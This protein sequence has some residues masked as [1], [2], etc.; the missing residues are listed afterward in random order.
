MSA[1]MEGISCAVIDVLNPFILNAFNFKL[2]LR[3]CGFA[4]TAS[5]YSNLINNT[6]PIL[7]K[8]GC[9]LVGDFLIIMRGK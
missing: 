4:H 9:N 5:K 6:L 7:I 2:S 1:M 3:E 8:F